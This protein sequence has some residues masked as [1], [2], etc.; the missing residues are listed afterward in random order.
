MN[1]L[2]LTQSNTLELFYNLNSQIRKTEPGETGFY[3]A[4]SAFYDN[5]QRNNPELNKKRYSL[6]GEWEVLD[7]AQSTTPDLK[8]LNDFEKKYSDTNIWNA[9]VS[10][11]RIILGKKAT[12][13]QDYSRRYSDDEML[14]ILQV[15]I[16]KI[17]QLFDTLK[18]DLVVSFISVTIGEYISNFVASNRKIKF[19][20]LRPTKIK[21]FFH[22]AESI[23]EPSMKI[24]TVYNELLSKG[25]TQEYRKDIDLFLEK[26]RSSHFMYEGVVP[27]T[28][29]SI[30]TVSVKKSKSF[31]ERFIWLFREF[32]LYNFTSLKFDNH[33]RGMFYP[34]FFNRIIKPIRMNKIERRLKKYYLNVTDLEKLDF[35][36]YPLHKEPEVTM[37]VYGNMYLNQIEVIRNI[38]NS[39]PVGMK[40]IVK[41]HPAGIGYHTVSFYQKLLAIPRVQLVPTK[42]TSHEILKHARL[43]VIISGSIGFEALIQKKPVLHFGNV[44]FS[45]LPENMIKKTNPQ[46]LKEDIKSI[47][48]NYCHDEEALRA[49]ISAMIQ[50]SVEV[51]FYTKLLGR[52][53]VF[54]LDS[55]N[56]R[57]KHIIKLADYILKKYNDL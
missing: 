47:L 16:Q 48:E 35:A 54:S 44:S 52:T 27:P 20:N 49:Y 53:G 33:Y 10:D 8:L 42:M 57:D 34:R 5:F 40:L 46:N 24:G 7:S 51:D 31:V 37:L 3:I 12:I 18:P 32:Y 9:V 6:L 45:W 15:G 14:S 19:I 1:I 11:R 13:T 26:S 39:L 4:D 41:D 28:V 22:G 23:F 43:I 21:N 30:N 17:E 56:S 36:F 38:A 2:Y 29:K 50:E 25:I 55:E